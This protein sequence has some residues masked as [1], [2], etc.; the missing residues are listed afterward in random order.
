MLA[1]SSMHVPAPFIRPSKHYFPRVLL[2]ANIRFQIFLATRLRHMIQK[3]VLPVE[4]L[5]FVAE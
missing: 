5:W 2:P 3:M 4:K 1:S